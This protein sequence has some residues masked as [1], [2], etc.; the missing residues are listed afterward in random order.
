MMKTKYL[1]PIICFLSAVLL[2]SCSVEK[3][4]SSVNHDSF[5]EV[6]ITF[7][8][9]ELERTEFN[10]YIYDI[11]PFQISCKLPENWEFTDEEEKGDQPG[12]NTFL[13]GG[14]WSNIQIISGDG[15]CVGAV[16]YNL[17]D[18]EMISYLET[19]PSAIYGQIS[20]GNGYHFDVGDTYQPLTEDESVALTGVIYSRS[21]LASYDNTEE[22]IV[23]KGILAYDKDRLVY[24]AFEF[25]TDVLDDQQWTQIAESISFSS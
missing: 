23:N 8:A 20:M 14:T 25:R 24:V 6:H 9:N 18:P 19:K 7:P 10:S 1:K 11:E 4:E 2:V 13:H 16:G 12:Q 17:I 21:F 22:E 15:E 3:K 5:H